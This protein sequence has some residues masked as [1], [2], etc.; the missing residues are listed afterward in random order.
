MCIRDSYN[1]ALGYDLAEGG[2]DW[3][4]DNFTQIIVFEQQSSGSNRPI[5]SS[6]DDTVGQHYEIS[7]DGDGDTFQLKAG[8]GEA[9]FAL[10]EDDTAELYAMTADSDG[11]TT[12]VDNQETDS[13]VTTSG[14]EFD[15][16]RLALNRADNKTNSIYIAEMIIYDRTLSRCE[17][18]LVTKYL[19]DKLSLIHISEPT[20]PY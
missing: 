7:T 8:G 18:R 19:S 9:D 11:F 4:G 6:G 3:T 2:E 20:R 12:F 14:R 10:W 1:D 16:Y 13:L 5:F 15:E 17:L